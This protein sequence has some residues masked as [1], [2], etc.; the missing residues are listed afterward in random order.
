MD[1]IGPRI[2]VAF[3]IVWFLLFLGAI[4]FFYGCKNA[5][6]KRRWYPRWGALAMV[7]FSAIALYDFGPAVLALLVPWC[8]FTY[9]VTTYTTEFCDNCGASLIN[10]YWT[11]KPRLRWT[12][13][14][15]QPDKV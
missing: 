4:A 12:P 3:F 8:I 11:A 13:K 6:I 14:T 9:F 7:C 1:K 10:K 15:G 5:E 2:D